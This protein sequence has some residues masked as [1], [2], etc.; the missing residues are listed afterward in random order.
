MVITSILTDAADASEAFDEKYGCANGFGCANIIAILI[1]ILFA[2]ISILEWLFIFFY[3]KRKVD[4]EE[5]DDKLEGKE[6][7][8]VKDDKQDDSETSKA[9]D[10][11]VEKKKDIFRYSFNSF[12]IILCAVGLVLTEY[13]LYR[14]EKNSFFIGY[15][16]GLIICVAEIIAIV[17]ANW[18]KWKEKTHFQGT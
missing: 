2:A 1:A 10:A 12:L 15:G 16:V 11:E 9:I 17:V 5:D 18:K 6:V 7:Q 8:P 14:G 4:G 13:D 3:I